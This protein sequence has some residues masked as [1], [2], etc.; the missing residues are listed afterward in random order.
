MLVVLEMRPGLWTACPAIS[1]AAVHTLVMQVPPVYKI[2][3]FV[4]EF[5][6]LNVPSTLRISKG[7]FKLSQE[8]C[9]YYRFIK[10]DIACLFLYFV[11][12]FSVVP[13]WRHQA[14]EWNNLL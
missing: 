10:H 4:I 8:V 11:F 14:S 5:K 9:R 3:S 1:L 12:F 7:G 6:K 2:V 13:E